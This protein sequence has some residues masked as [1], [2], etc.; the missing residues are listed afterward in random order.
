M[1]QPRIEEITLYQ[2]GSIPGIPGEH[3]AGIAT[4]DWNARQ[5]LSIR[6]FP[7]PAEGEGIGE[8]SPQVQETATAGTTILF[9]STPIISISSNGG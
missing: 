2:A 6:P 7:T 5:V 4:V 9:A 8:V 3:P 1:T